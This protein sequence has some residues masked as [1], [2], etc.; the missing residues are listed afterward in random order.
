ML[1]DIIIAEP[2]AYIAFAGKRVTLKKTVPDGSQAAE[3]LFHKGDPIVPRNPLEHHNIRPFGVNA[4][5]GESIIRYPLNYERIEWKKSNETCDGYRIT[6]FDF[7]NKK[8]FDL[9]LRSPN[10]LKFHPSSVLSES[11]WKKKKRFTSHY[12]QGSPKIMKPGGCSLFDQ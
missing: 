9:F 8:P 5:N 11:S 6:S 10:L 7:V 2:N 1:G 4:L 12:I 3:S